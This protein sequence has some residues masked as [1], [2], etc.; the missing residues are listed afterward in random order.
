[1]QLQRERR[2]AALVLLGRGRTVSAQLTEVAREAGASV[3]RTD[4]DGAVRVQVRGNRLS[5]R[6]FE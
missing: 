3:F 1:M 4:T 5:V 6:T 2:L